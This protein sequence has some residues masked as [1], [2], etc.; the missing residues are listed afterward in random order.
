MKQMNANNADLPAGS[1]LA[2]RAARQR[3][4]TFKAKKDSGSVKGS[5]M[6][7]RSQLFDTGKKKSQ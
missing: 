6:N 4:N 7:L 2:S 3:Q 5:S 1:L